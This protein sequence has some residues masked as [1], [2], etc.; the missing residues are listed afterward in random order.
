MM[1]RATGVVWMSD[2]Q[3]IASA[4]RL[5]NGCI[6]DARLLAETGSRNAAYLGEQ[7]IEQVIRALAT[8][9]AIHI[10]RN[11]AH[12]LDKVVRRFPDNHAEKA[13]L[14][15][16]VWLEAYATTFRYTLPSGQIPRAPTWQSLSTPSKT[17]LT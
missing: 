3:T 4:L 10:E 2:N 9:E 7:A 8:S 17:L 11:D 13:A 1:S 5:A 14:K 6:R 15:S 16:V 12:Q